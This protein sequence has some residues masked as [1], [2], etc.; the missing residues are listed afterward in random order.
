MVSVMNELYCHKNSSPILQM[1]YRVVGGLKGV[2]KNFANFTGKHLSAGVSFIMK[3]QVSWI[4]SNFYVH[5][6]CVKSVEI[7]S[8]FWSVFPYFRT[9]YGYL[10]SKYPYSVGIQENTDQK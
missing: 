6:H 3:V 1:F 4:K 8:Y 2:I 10:Q 9:K 5:I 7:R